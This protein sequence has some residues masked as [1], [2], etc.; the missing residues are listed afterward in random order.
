MFATWCHQCCNRILTTLQACARRAG[1]VRVKSRDTTAASC[2]ALTVASSL[3]IP[4]WRSASRPLDMTNDFGPLPRDEC[5][6][7]IRF[8][9][10]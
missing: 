10:A 2:S 5:K 4:L 9:T 8:A 7:M 6:R 3:Y 1:P